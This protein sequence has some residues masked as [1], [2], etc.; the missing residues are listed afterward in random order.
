DRPPLIAVPRPGAESAS[1]AGIRGRP[2]MLRHFSADAAHVETTPNRAHGLVY[3][4]GRPT[5]WPGALPRSTTSTS[6]AGTL[7]DSFW[8][9]WRGGLAFPAARPCGRHGAVRADATPQPR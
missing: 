1:P 8:E 7:P 5:C 3:I 2:Q 4:H 9:C 6:S